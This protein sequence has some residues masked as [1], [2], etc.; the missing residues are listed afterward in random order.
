MFELLRT[1]TLAASTLTMGL[2][3]GLFYS[4]AC[5]VMLGLSR[6]DDRSFISAMQW[7]NVKILNG[8]FALAFAGALILTI[9]AGALHLSGGGRPVLPWIVAGLVLYGVVLVVTFTVNVPLNDQ[10]AAAGDPA[11]IADPAAV[12]QAFEAKWVRWNTVRAVASTAAFGCLVW[13]LIVH[14]GTA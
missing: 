1:A 14:G 5:A 2:T 4:F 11:A 3:A 10:L 9:A 7:I 12:R 6:T 13:A 8:W